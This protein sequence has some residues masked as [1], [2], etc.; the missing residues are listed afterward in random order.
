MKAE[1]L[2]PSEQRNCEKEL[3]EAQALIARMAAI[4]RAD[5]PLSDSESL[6]RLEKHLV[7]QAQQLAAQAFQQVLQ[8]HLYDDTTEQRERELAGDLSPKLKK[9]GI[10]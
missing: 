5:Y 3:P 7:A 6:E 10:C 1:N 4:A 9:K 2:H 8:A